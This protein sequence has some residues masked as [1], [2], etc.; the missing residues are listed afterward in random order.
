MSSGGIEERNQFA[1]EQA[2]IDE[3]HPSHLNPAFPLDKAV[4]E[5][6]ASGVSWGLGQAIWAYAALFLA[7]IPIAI[8]QV[9]FGLSAAAITL[10]GEL[11]FGVGAWLVG[12]RVARERGGWSRAFGF[13][14]PARP[15]LSAAA[16]FAGLQ[17]LVRVALVAL[18][19]QALP[20]LRHEQVS[21]VPATGGYGAAVVAQL[22]LAV[23]VVAPVVEE[24][25]F[26]GIILR[27]LMRRWNF[28]VSAAICG[29]AFGLIHALGGSG[30]VALTLGLVMTA[31][32]YL[33]CVLV[34]RTGGLAAA[35]MVHG[36]TNGIA[37]AVALA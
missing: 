31:F 26:R 25:L 9:A 7:A 17:L 36:V 16:A 21:N 35:M 18:L 13:G 19:L 6:L 33:Q 8:L 10:P 37:M 12:R 23:V 34:R 20:G 11:S 28:H 4:I 3:Q 1:V 2:A 15:D 27:A 22:L 30:A 5:D 24:T 29:V 14:R 32:G